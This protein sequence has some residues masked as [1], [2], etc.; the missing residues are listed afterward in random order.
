MTQIIKT[1]KNNAAYRFI[2]KSG[3]AIRKHIKMWGIKRKLHKATPVF[4]FQMGKVA[5]ST[6][7]D[8]LSEQ[9]P[10][11]VAHAHFIGE[12]NWASVLFYEWAKSGKPL[13]IISPVRDPV[14][15]NI[16]D[17]FQLFRDYTGMDVNS[18]DLDYDIV[19]EKF[20]VNYNHMLPL[21]WFDKMIKHYFDIDIY[22]YD[23][24]EVGYAIYT[25]NNISLLVF[26]IDIP[27]STKEKAI[28][29][30]LDFDNIHLKKSNVA[31]SKQYASLYTSFQQKLTLPD[32]YLDMMCTSKYTRHFFS[33]DEIKT[34]KQRWGK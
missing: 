13:K 7:F 8:T 10:G 22:K 32:E 16:S 31:S 9:Y 33:P 29:D 24:P 4:V 17:F 21:T 3:K 19:Y 23:F 25:H 28:R 18:K 2:R 1:L 34:I 11:A 26:R 20:L 12:D 5:S 30:F 14:S 15:R 6:I 27:D